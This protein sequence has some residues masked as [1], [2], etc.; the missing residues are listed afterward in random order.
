MG[1]HLLLLCW[2]AANVAAET[3]CPPE[4]FLHAVRFVES[5]HGRFTWGDRG[6]SLGE[7]QLSEAAW[8]DVT[9][10]RK[11]RGLPTYDY[12]VH[13]WNRQV[14]RAYAADYLA[15]LRG[16]LKRR[17]KRPPT[18]AEIYAAYN[19]GLS[20]FAECDYRLANVNPLTAKKCRQIMA[21]LRAP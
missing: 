2:L 10:W 6:R 14:S 7:F 3:W 12:S 21:M 4:E 19:M 11:A 20:S 15:L 8:L 18:V 16:E 9:W 13:V 1:K 17:M 5:S